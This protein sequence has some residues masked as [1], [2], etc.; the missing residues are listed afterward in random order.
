MPNQASAFSSSS[1]TEEFLLGEREFATLRRL[2]FDRSGIDISPAKRQLVKTRLLKRLRMRGCAGFE[3]YLFLLTQ[4]GEE[5]ELKQVVDLLTTNETYFFREPAHFLFVEG[6][7]RG[8]SQRAA[9]PRLWSAA[10]STGEEAY[11]LAMVMANVLG[12]GKCEIVG[13]D[14]SSQVVERARVGVYPAEAINNIPEA[15]RQRYCW[16][17]TGESAGFIKIDPAIRRGVR[18]HERSLLNP[19]EDLGDFDL[20]FLRNCLIYFSP[21]KKR[22]IVESV[23]KR[24][25]P[26]GRLIVGH[27]ESLHGVSP[28]L[29]QE[30][31]S[32]YRCVA[33]EGRI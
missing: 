10:S 15:L 18:F 26:E 12:T 19:L 25:R 32:I 16:R 9:P 27:S 7:A 20:I 11:S 13:T 8:L 28:L 30:A 5:E 22:E 2:F 31:V 3:E 21:E 14:L 1:A 17:G 29:K 23:L 6:W 24:L 4:R 33:H